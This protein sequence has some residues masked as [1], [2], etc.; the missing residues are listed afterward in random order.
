MYYL[1]KNLNTQCR[2]RSQLTIPRESIIREKWVLERNG[3]EKDN[4]INQEVLEN[5][6]QSPLNLT[7]IFKSYFS[8]CTSLNSSQYAVQFYVTNVYFISQNT[9]KNYLYGPWQP[10]GRQQT[11]KFSDMAFLVYLTLYSL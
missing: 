2:T 8:N 1:Y 9:N 4:S 6:A 5:L 3:K 10:A 7:T 11:S